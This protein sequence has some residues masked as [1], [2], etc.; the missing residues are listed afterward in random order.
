MAY[1][2]GRNPERQQY[3]EWH[4]YGKERGFFDRAADEIRSWFGD[5]E[6]EQRR[7]LDQRPERGAD[8]EF[9]RE[10]GRRR[11]IPEWQRRNYSGS[12]PRG[13]SFTERGRYDEPSSR[14]GAGSKRGRSEGRRSSRFFEDNE[15]SYNPFVSERYRNGERFGSER[16]TWDRSGIESPSGFE[17]ESLSET[18]ESRLGHR[19]RG[20]RNYRRSDERII[21]EINEALMLH[22]DLD[23]SEIDVLIQDGIVT[24]RGLVDCR[25]SKHLAEYVTEE[26]FGVR[27]VRNELRTDKGPM[28]NDQEQPGKTNI[29]TGR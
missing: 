8:R 23:A 26:V 17:R 18:G 4:R 1:Y 5:E 11:R 29:S 20:P 28:G 6:A 27:E 16:P 19:G 10:Y 9:G 15:E 13:S 22:P 14:G 12:S 2:P 7:N 25:H 24:L 3:E 21:D